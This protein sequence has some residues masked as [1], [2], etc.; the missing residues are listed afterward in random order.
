MSTPNAGNSALKRNYFPK[1]QSAMS[2][3]LIIIAPH[4]LRDADSASA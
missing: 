1:G 4:V 2:T 3:L